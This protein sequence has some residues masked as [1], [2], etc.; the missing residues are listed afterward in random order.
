[1][2]QLPTVGLP[3]ER[4]VYDE[5][6]QPIALAGNAGDNPPPNSLCTNPDTYG[7]YSNTSTCR[8]DSAPYPSYSNTNVAYKDSCSTNGNPDATYT[9]SYPTNTNA[10]PTNTNAYPTNT[11]ADTAYGNSYASDLCR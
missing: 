11:N 8:G 4:R 5:T 6:K 2:G 10:Y 3:I 1:M 7:S 9:H